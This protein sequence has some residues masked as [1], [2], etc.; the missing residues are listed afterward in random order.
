MRKWRQ[1]WGVSLQRRLFVAFGMTIFL[2]MGA[3]G[4]T[5]HLTQPEGYNL[6]DRYRQIERFAA[7]RFAKVWADAGERQELAQGLRESFG[8]DL[9]VR[10]PSG[11]VLDRVGET[12]DH[13]LFKIDVAHAGEA[14]GTVEGCPRHG[15]K[16]KLSGFL[17][18]LAAA[19]LTLWMGSGA[20][21]RKIARPLAELA[22]VARDLGH[23]KLKRRARLR[24]HVPGEVGELAISINEM[25]ERIAKQL[26]DQRELLAAVSHE[27]R[28]PLA[29]LRVLIDLLEDANCDQELTQQLEREVIEIDQLTEDLLASSRLD[30]QALNRRPLGASELARRALE[31]CNLSAD[32]LHAPD[33]DVE[34]LGDA[35]LLGRALTNLLVNAQCHGGGVERLTIQR[36]NGRVGFSVCDRGPGFTEDSLTRAFE[37]FYQ[38]SGPRHKS[39]SSLGL[40]LALV[41]RIAR[42]HGGDA[43]ARN[44]PDGGAEVGFSVDRGP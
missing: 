14:L 12:C 7:S 18:A 42:A 36:E 38:G 10:D 15:R 4:L 30:F 43:F 25:A 22:G 6:H 3:V 8:V 20:I 39:G 9:I 16:R 26:D 44:R 11:R 5:M 35:T 19:A 27:I 28:T 37:R 23:G 29:R 13:V 2:T 40:G 1:L 17:L 31:R 41:R 33:E 34:L 21:A 32:L 24:R